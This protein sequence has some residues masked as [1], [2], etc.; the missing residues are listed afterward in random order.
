MLSAIFKS[1][2]SIWG[3]DTFKE[4]RKLPD[5]HVQLLELDQ[6]LKIDFHIFSSKST[7]AYQDSNLGPAGYEPVALPLSYRPSALLYQIH[8]G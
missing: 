3:G 5:L 2:F 8:R 4:E 6:L 7:W 1:M